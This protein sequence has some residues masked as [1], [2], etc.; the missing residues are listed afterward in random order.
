[1]E[2]ML[3]LSIIN[4]DVDS[5]TSD[6]LK[7]FDIMLASE[8]FKEYH[9]VINEK[10]NEYKDSIPAPVTS[11][12]IDPHTGE[13]YKTLNGSIVIILEIDPISKLAQ[14]FVIKGGMSSCDKEIINKRFNATFLS[15][16][17]IETVSGY[18][19]INFKGK[20]VQMEDHESFSM[21]IASKVDAAFGEKISNEQKGTA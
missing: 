3:K 20:F 14:C 8:N 7:S 21:H 6:I 4:T 13:F 1:M 10:L 2:D 16:T 18:Y 11:I 12:E 19:V 5:M 17:K 9:N 15:Q